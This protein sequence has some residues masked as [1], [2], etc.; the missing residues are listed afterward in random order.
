VVYKALGLVG[1]LIIIG[2]LS[3]VFDLTMLRCYTI[4]MDSHVMVDNRHFHLGERNK[5]IRQAY[6]FIDDTFPKNAI[7]QH[8]YDTVIDYGG[9]SIPFG[10]YSGLYG[11]RQVILADKYQALGFAGSVRNVPEITTSMSTIFSPDTKDVRNVAAICAK[12]NIS[13]VLVRDTDSLWAA[14]DSWIWRGTP[15]FDN[16]YVKVFNFKAE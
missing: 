14:K 2:I 10:F 3:T 9:Y 11:N 6:T 7:I 16:D 1:P 15:V 4:F 13:A 12:F 5:A 8:N